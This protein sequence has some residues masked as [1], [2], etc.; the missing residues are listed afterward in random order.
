MKQVIVRIKKGNRT[1]ASAYFYSKSQYDSEVLDFAKQLKV[2][3]TIQISFGRQYIVFYEYEQLVFYT[4]L[5]NCNFEEQLYSSLIENMSIQW[6]LS[7]YL[8]RY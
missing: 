2:G 8:P 3:Q 5:N 7:Q 6:Y 1:L 4:K